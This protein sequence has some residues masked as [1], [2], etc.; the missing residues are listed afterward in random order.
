M[1][2]RMLSGRARR[3]RQAVITGTTAQE[4]GVPFVRTAYTWLAYL[5]LGYFAYLQAI[6]GPVM[7]FLRAELRLNYVEGSAHVSALA[8]GTMGA[9]LV[10]D[11]LARRWGRGVVLW[12]GA[13]GVAVG[14][15]GL[16]VGR[17]AVVTVS[18]ALVIGGLG[19]LLMVMVQATLADQ[20]GDRRA[21]ALVE[22][23]VI[24]SAC[25]GLAPLLVGA[26]AGTA[27]GWR[28][29]LV[30][31]IA[32]LGALALAGRHI[33]VPAETRASGVVEQTRGASSGTGAQ[34]PALPGVFWAYWALTVLVVAAEW[35]VIVWS[36]DYLHSVGGLSRGGAATAVSA[37]FI[38]EVTGRFVGSRLARWVSTPRLLALSLLLTLAGFPLFWLGPVIPV[39]IAGLF[40]A[41]LGIANLYPLTLAA[42][43]GVAAAQTDRASARITLAVGA[44]IFS[45]PLLLGWMA[46]TL[47]LERAYAIVPVLVILAG[48]TLI[49]AWAR[50]APRAGGG[51]DGDGAVARSRNA[52]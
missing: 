38:A 18:A 1:L 22:S 6:L 35:C 14:A 50:A 40:I 4:A 7:P 10:G 21:I 16:A 43:T 31:D 34:R 44:A 2:T 36:A 24:A 29:A 48:A 49:G 12:G 37:F 3:N 13:A 11:R 23:N 26:F 47:G 20:Y 41:G 5:L 25:A 30:A 39:R 8:L 33:A 9:G 28:G 45:A 19:T 46:D 42:A 27:I 15:A 32:V 51:G 17:S 52:R